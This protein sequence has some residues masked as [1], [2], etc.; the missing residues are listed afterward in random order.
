MRLRHPPQPMQRQTQSGG[1]M[2]RTL[3]AAVSLAA[4][5]YA[6]GAYADPLGAKAVVIDGYR[7]GGGLAVGA[8]KNLDAVRVLIGAADAMGQLRD[9]QY[10]GSTY[11]VIG[12]TTNGMRVDADGTW[13]GAKS[14]VVLDW[15]YRVPGVRLDVTSADGKTRAITV[16]A[17]NLAWDEKTPGVFGGQAA[18]SV[19]DRLIV[20]M[21][22]PSEVILEARDAADTIKLSR[23]PNN[24]HQVLTIP[25]PKLGAGV[26]M[27]AS[28]DADSH[29][30]HTQIAYNGHTYTGDFGNFLS[31]R[32]DMMVQFPHHIVLQTD[33]KET[34]NLDLN[35]HQ[36]NPYLIFPVPKE[37]ASK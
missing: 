7:Y 2:R 23:D 19:N 21:L 9:N 27:V 37:V 22:M 24:G 1:N 16:A 15:D 3:M 28:L 33:G 5:A 26:N 31:D 6:T 12:D 36:A 17:G 34:A 20:P 8:D 18:T 30:I 32:M 13:N 25:L 10:G 35:W 4:L 11:L 29:P 14:H